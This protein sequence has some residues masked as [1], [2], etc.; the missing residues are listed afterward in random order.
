MFH[1]KQHEGGRSMKTVTAVY[2]NAIV[3]VHHPELTSEERERIIEKEVKP[4][5]AW[6]GRQL[7]QQPH[8]RYHGR[9]RS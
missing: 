7:P 4:A 5:L 2:G 6:F 3:R 1:V 8:G 9:G